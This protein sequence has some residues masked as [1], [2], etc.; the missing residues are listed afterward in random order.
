M[1]KDSSSVWGNLVT[2]YEST[3]LRTERDEA[4]GQ[5]AM[6]HLETRGEESIAMIPIRASP[7]R[8]SVEHCIHLDPR[9]SVP[10]QGSI[11]GY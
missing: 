2:I 3:N 7:A 4:W 9:G 6:G 5:W 11:H 1:M 10:G 8:M